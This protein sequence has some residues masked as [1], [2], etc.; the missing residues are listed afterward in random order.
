LGYPVGVQAYKLYDLDSNS[1][2]LSRGVQFHEDFFPFR[3]TAHQTIVHAPVSADVPNLVLPSFPSTPFVDYV[4]PYSYSQ[5]VDISSSFPFS[6]TAPNSTA[7]LIDL[8]PTIPDSSPIT[9]V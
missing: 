1:V 7:D 9:S 5:S 2:F 3:D 4:S 8:A 6:V